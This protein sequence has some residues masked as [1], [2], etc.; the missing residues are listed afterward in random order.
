MFDHLPLSVTKKM[1]SNDRRALT[2]SQGAV[3]VDLGS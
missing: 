2:L 3:L 1:L